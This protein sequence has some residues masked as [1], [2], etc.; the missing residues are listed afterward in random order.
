MNIV[1][2]QADLSDIGLFQKLCKLY[3]NDPRIDIALCRYGMEQCSNIPE[4][5]SIWLRKKEKKCTTK[6]HRFICELL[7]SSKPYFSANSLTLL[8]I[9]L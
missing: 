7:R 4:W 6:L 2:G 5:T 9:A 3:K 8:T 1:F